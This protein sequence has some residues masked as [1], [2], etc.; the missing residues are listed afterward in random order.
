MDTFISNRWGSKAV[1]ASTIDQVVLYQSKEEM[2]L[3]M[4]LFKS[5]DAFAERD[6]RGFLFGKY[7]N[8]VE[9]QSMMDD[10]I[11]QLNGGF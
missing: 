7:E 1:R 9:A 5:H 10:V 4:G 8:H 3:V 11:K 2:W 6:S